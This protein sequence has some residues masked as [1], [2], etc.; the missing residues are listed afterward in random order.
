MKKLKKYWKF[1]FFL[2]WFVVYNLDI[3]YLS[4]KI[5]ELENQLYEKNYEEVKEYPSVAI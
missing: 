5:Y 4:S 2:S 1:L 3:S